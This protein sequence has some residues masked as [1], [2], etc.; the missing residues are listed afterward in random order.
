MISSNTIIAMADT[1]A[2]GSCG[3]NG[4]NVS[5]SLDSNGTLSISGNN[6]RMAD[7][8]SGTAPWYGYREQIKYV[9]IENGVINI[10]SYA[11]KDCYNIESVSFGTI[12]TIGNNAFD[13]CTKLKHAILPDSCTWIWGY[14]FQNCT[15]LQSAYVNACNSY[16]NALPNGMFDGCT[17][18]A[19]L[20]LGSSITV[21]NEYSLQNCSSLTA[22]IINGSNLTVNANA[23]NNIDKSKC[24]LVSASSNISSFA[25]SNGWAYISTKSG[26]ASNNT[27]SSNKLTY[28]WDTKTSTLSFIGSGDM[29]GYENGKQ[30]WQMFTGAMNKIDF[31]NTDGKVS[32]STTAFQGRTA[33]ESVDFT[34]VFAIGWGAFA[35]CS[36]LKRVSFAPCLEAIWNYAFANDTSIDQVLFSDG[37]NDLHIYP[38][39]FNN[40]SGTTY[41][42]NLPANTKYIDDHAFFGTGFNYVTINS[43]NVTMGED[44]FGNGEGGYSRFFGVASANTG[45]YDWVKASREN[46]N[47]NWFYYCLNDAHTYSSWTIEPTC[48]QKGYDVYGC[49]YCD[50]DQLKDNYQ[51]SYGHRFKIEEIKD[52]SLLYSCPNCGV[53]NLRVGAGELL[54][55]FEPSISST[56]GSFVFLQDNY[57]GL[58]DLDF[59]GVINAKDYSQILNIYLSVNTTNKQT[60]INTSKAYQTIDGFGASGCWWSQSVGDWENADEIIGL[61]YDEEDGIGLD[62]YRYNLGAG[63]RDINDTTMYIEDERTNC[64][65]Q[66]NGTY[67][68][69]NDQTALNALS[70]A[71]SHNSDLKVTL[72][73]NSPPVY[74]TENGKAY[75]T[76]DTSSNISKSNYQAYANYITTCAEH[77]IDEGYNV[78]EVSPINEPEWGW[79]GWYN[80]DGSISCGQEGC[81]W[82]Y[83]NALDFY[84]NYMIPTMRNNNKLN[85]RVGL[86]VWES[87][88]MDHNDFWDNYLNNLFSSKP[89]KKVLG[90]VTQKGYAENNG[91][92][93]SYVDA[94]DIHSYWADPSARTNVI[95]DINDQYFGQKIRCSEYCQMYNDYN[96]GVVAHINAEGGS[97]KGLSIDYGLAMADIIYQDMT[98]LNA[99]EWDWWTAVG[100]GVYTDSLIY[101]NNTTHSYETSKRLYCLGNYSKFIDEGAVRVEVSTGSAFGSNLQTNPENIYSWDDEYGNHVVDRY[102]YIEQSAYLNPDGSVVVVYIN[103]S[104]SVE[105]TSFDS[106]KF[107]SFETIVTDANRNLEAVQNDTT[108]HAV[109]I[110]ARSVTTVVLH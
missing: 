104:D 89:T 58:F 81:T 16:P 28:S 87:G 59:N 52:G 56:A 77:F 1:T 94:V 4:N 30:P 17:S 78:T 42:I 7:Y 70:I 64:F 24:Y 108:N 61:L 110:P 46:K 100:K 12:D 34:N 13:S 99:V 105:Y 101:V 72:F 36:G 44:A 66:P 73:A 69:A 80:G 93:R 86:S 67:N 14:A 48:T 6:Q 60:T 91:N 45:V 71:N 22:L 85:G 32:V 8:S 23:V 43:P 26:I 98:I 15:S 20:E 27:Y 18:L 63:S 53:K 33:I 3:A 102:N 97:T 10:G 55:D 5:W 65:L 31:S 92:I 106:S 47:Y 83:S 107:S 82:S 41:W 62:I 9:Q 84:N 95:N 39:A 103:N 38:W 74:M 51:N 21:L 76:P 35:E 96:T 37:T 40:C 54:G 57:N 68:W 25:N 2:S 11:F 88:Q 29:N 90:I 19:V 109:C 49:P 50:V 75:V 79:T